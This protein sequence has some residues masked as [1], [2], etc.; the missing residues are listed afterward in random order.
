MGNISHI[1]YIIHMAYVLRYFMN[2]LKSPAI[3]QNYLNYFKDNILNIFSENI[4]T[5]KETEYFYD[6]I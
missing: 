6:N 2:Y 3:T 4:I 5:L 1:N